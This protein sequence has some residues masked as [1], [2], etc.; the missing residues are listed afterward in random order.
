MW[1][2]FTCFHVSQFII[3][4]VLRMKIQ[5]CT[6]L[7]SRPE[8][9]SAP[10]ITEK[11]ASWCLWAVLKCSPWL[12]R[13]YSAS[14]GPWTRSLLIETEGRRLVPPIPNTDQ[15]HGLAVPLFLAGDGAEGPACRKIKTVLITYLIL[16]VL[17][18]G[19]LT[20]CPWW[21]LLDLLQDILL[22]TF[23]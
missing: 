10:G 8:S 4:T 13:L 17:I 20:S 14:P 6:V 5:I 1:N 23:T 19:Y 15:N 2:N 9:N 3:I 11:L 18:P 7:H 22:A 12:A 21:S 16:N